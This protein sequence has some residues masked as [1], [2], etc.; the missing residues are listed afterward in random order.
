MNLKSGQDFTEAF[1][2]IRGRSIG[3]EDFSMDVGNPEVVFDPIWSRGYGNNVAVYSPKEIKL[4]GPV[5]TWW[6]QRKPRF[7]DKSI[8]IDTKGLHTGNQSKIYPSDVQYNVNKYIKSVGLPKSYN[9]TASHMIFL[10]PN[11]GASIAD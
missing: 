6:S 1:S 5:E 3:K 9:R 10:S 7:Q 8:Y 11:E 4:N 2:T